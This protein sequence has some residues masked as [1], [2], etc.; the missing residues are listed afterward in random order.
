MSSHHVIRWVRLADTGCDHLA[1]PRNSYDQRQVSWC[2]FTLDSNR[3]SAESGLRCKDCLRLVEAFTRQA[4]APPPETVEEVVFVHVTRPA[5]ARETATEAI[6]RKMSG[7][8]TWKFQ[9]RSAE[10]AE[11]ATGD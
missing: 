9:V 3:A 6:L 1:V 7:L 5:S 10:S 4:C 11:V 2:G 8:K